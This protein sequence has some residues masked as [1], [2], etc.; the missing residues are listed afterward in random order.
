MITV[1]ITQKGQVVIPKKLRD[2][3]GIETRGK[4]LVT[5][6]GD[7]IAVLPFVSDPIKEG[8]GMLKFDRP[9]HEVMSEMKGEERQLE[10]KRG[11]RVPEK[12]EPKKRRRRQ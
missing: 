3:Y 6:I 5:E 4:V 9:L 12:K 8:R 11:N 7:H 10:A 2:K 1:S